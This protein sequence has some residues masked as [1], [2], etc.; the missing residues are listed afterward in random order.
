LDLVLR[1]KRL[2]IDID[3]KL[4]FNI[5]DQLS[6]LIFQPSVYGVGELQKGKAFG[7]KGENYST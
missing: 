4:I 2:G 7:T 5:A 1:V 6:K 3:Y